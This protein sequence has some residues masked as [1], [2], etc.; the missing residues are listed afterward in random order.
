MVNADQALHWNG[1]GGIQMSKYMTEFAKEMKIRTN[2]KLIG[3]VLS[4]EPLQVGILNNV[5]ILDDSNC[6]L[7]SNLSKLTIGDSVLVISDINEQ[8]FFIIDKV[9]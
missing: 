1:K 3:N 5:A 9:M 2:N 4:V 7:C 6:Y 8:T